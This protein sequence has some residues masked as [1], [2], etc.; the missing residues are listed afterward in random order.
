MTQRAKL[1]RA[2]L[3]LLSLALWTTWELGRDCQS[4]Y[5]DLSCG[6]FTDHFSH[7]NAARIF[8]RI[9]ADIWR[10]PLKSM[11]RALSP[12]EVAR[13]PEYAHV[14]ER[15]DILSVP[16]WKFEKPLAA[17]WAHNPRLYPPGDMLLVAPVAFLYHYT[18]L[19][20]ADASVILIVLFLVYAHLAIYV[21]LS[22]NWPRLPL[23][24]TLL[25][26]F[27]IIHWTLEG[28]YD[29][30]A[31]FPLLLCTVYLRRGRGLAALVAY[32]ASVFIHYRALFFLPWGVYAAI[33]IIRERQWQRWSAPHYLAVAGTSLMAVA[34]AI[35][36]LLLWPTLQHLPNVNPISFKS[37]HPEYAVLSCVGVA[38]VISAATFLWNKCWLDMAIL[39]WFCF[40][41]V[42]LRETYPW[43]LLV[44]LSWLAAPVMQAKAT[45]QRPYST[46]SVHD[47]RVFMLSFMG[48]FVFRS[49]P[50]PTWLTRVF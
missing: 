32:V 39:G 4:A 44:P 25:L 45:K 17:S 47:A 16:G 37:D 28:F 1:T 14:P 20:L 36:F 48:L 27:E 12:E 6:Q 18:G 41:I 2:V 42:S 34:A 35:P 49:N 9:G 26:Y 10:R 30:T 15:P 43:H 3:V 31:L 5:H 40:M 46:F 50:W 13:L 19:R 24:A 22:S 38:V 23:L 7:M 29:A 11:F 21:A 8:P 33:L